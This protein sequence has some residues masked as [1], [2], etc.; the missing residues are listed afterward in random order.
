MDFIDWA[1]GQPDSHFGREDCGSFVTNSFK[2][3]D[4]VCDDLLPF[5]CEAKQGKQLIMSLFCFL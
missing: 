2:M 1:D 5:V 4:Y 3:A